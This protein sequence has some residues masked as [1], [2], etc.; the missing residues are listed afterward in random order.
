MK[1]YGLY[2]MR[3]LNFYFSKFWNIFTHFP[4]GA[5]RWLKRETFTI[6]FIFFRSNMQYNFRENYSP[7]PLSS[8]FYGFCFIKLLF[9]FIFQRTLYNLLGKNLF[10][11][12]PDSFLSLI[13]YV[14]LSLCF[15]S[16]RFFFFCFI[17]V[18]FLFYFL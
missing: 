4:E 11:P 3:S 12:I 2:S 17:I 5:M 15:L 9:I 18:F 7:F 1:T 13:L 14:T 8:K 6:S 16:F 10:I